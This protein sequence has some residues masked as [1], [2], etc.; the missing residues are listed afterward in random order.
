[1][2]IFADILLHKLMTGS[3]NLV[4]EAVREVVTRLKMTKLTFHKDSLISFLQLKVLRQ[5][6]EKF[7]ILSLW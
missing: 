5:D 4:G 7:V 3:Y 2:G 1:M 6:S